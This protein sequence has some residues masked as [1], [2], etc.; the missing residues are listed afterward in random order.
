MSCDTVLLRLHIIVPLL[1]RIQNWHF[2]SSL[3]S[4]KFIRRP[5]GPRPAA[6]SMYLPCCPLRSE[7]FRP[8]K[9]C[10]TC[11][12]QE[13]SRHLA[14]AQRYISSQISAGFFFIHRHLSKAS[15]RSA[16]GHIPLPSQFTSFYASPSEQVTVCIQH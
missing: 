1:Y 9:Q 13:E 7:Y 3:R 5:A 15:L 10:Q 2:T 16:N 12:K 4:F 14:E 8:S 6:Q 11:R